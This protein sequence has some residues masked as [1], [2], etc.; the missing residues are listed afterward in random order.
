MEK[1]H[2]S[3]D[4]GYKGNLTD[5]SHLCRKRIGPTPTLGQVEFEATLRGSGVA[6]D[7]NMQELEKGWWNIPKKDRKELPKFLP[8]LQDEIN[9]KKTLRETMKVK[10]LKRD[11]NSNGPLPPSSLCS[12]KRDEEV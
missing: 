7:K 9:Q 1:K 12:N 8:R 4:I 3:K 5:I 10:T 2:S 6:T 11:K